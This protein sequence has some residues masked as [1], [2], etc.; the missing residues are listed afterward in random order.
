MPRRPTPNPSLQ[1]GGYTPCIPVG[2]NGAGEFTGRYLVLLRAGATRNAVQSLRD[3]AGLDDVASTADYADGLDLAEV[4]DTPVIVFD[5][6]GVAVVSADPAQVD[7]LTAAMDEDSPLLAIEPERIMHTFA[8]GPVAEDAL[9]YLRG[10]RD[11]VVTLHN[12]LTGGDGLGLGGEVAETF[13]DDAVSTWGLKATRT[14]SSRFS[15]R[16]VRVAILD[17]GIDLGHP[18]FLGWIAPAHARSFIAGESVQDGRGH[19]THVTGIACGAERLGTGPRYGVAFRTDIF[20]GKVLSNAG[21]G[22]D[23]SILAGI[24]WA[25]TN[26]CRVASMSLGARVQP[27]EAISVVY[28]NVARRCLAAGMLI[29]AAAGNDSDRRSDMIKPV[30]RP[31]NCPSIMAVGALDNRLG[32]GFFS[33][34]GINPNGGGVDIAAPGVAVLSSLPL[35]ARTGILTGT[36]I[37]TPHVA[38]LAAL[39][40]EARGVTGGALWSAVTGSARRLALPSRDVGAGLAQAPQ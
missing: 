8:T 40:F 3:V 20:S 9:E 25:L 37:A 24:E 13:L 34:G 17:T 22:P 6:L 7:A 35:P 32:V 21:R 15:G 31:A 30:A 2:P 29:V 14:L 36:S 12:H 39:W 38:G 28:E 19:G 4:S 5:R 16:G 10:Y 27:R 33:N 23:C 18:D 26:N 11:A 1:N